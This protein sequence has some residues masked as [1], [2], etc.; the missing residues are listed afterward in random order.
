MYGVNGWTEALYDDGPAGGFVPTD[1]CV[2]SFLAVTKDTSVM[3]QEV[4]EANLQG[5]LV[6]LP[7]GQLRFAVGASHR[8]NTY[9]Y[10]PDALN[11]NA[12]VRDSAAG[13]YPGDASYGSISAD[14]I[15][16]ELLVPLLADKPG[17]RAMS[18][19][20]GYRSSKNEP[21]KDVDS[22]KA[23]L[24]WRITDRVRLRGGHQ[25]ANRAPNVAELFQSSEQQFY[26]TNNGDWCSEENPTNPFAPNPANNPN[27]SQVRAICESL[28]G[29]AGASVVSA[30]CASFSHFTA[31]AT[32]SLYG[33]S[34]VVLPSPR[35]ASS[36]RPVT[37]TSCVA[38][39]AP[40]HGVPA[41]A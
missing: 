22:Y 32:C 4:A 2:H 25:V 24:D 21:S 10:I 13:I 16:G 40:S 18:L 38:S 11:T 36:A 15:Y 26:Y 41:P 14:D 31:R 39:P 30:S 9:N 12:A 35:K 19:E 1:D 34:R 17:V 33:P 29:V 37:P 7:A 6:D 8:K 3:E 20:L 23:L 5:G 27:A 28:M